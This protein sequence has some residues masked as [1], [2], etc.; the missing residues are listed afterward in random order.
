M[1]AGA[2]KVTITPPVGTNMAGFGARAHGS[3]ASQ[4]VHD[5]LYAKALVFEAGGEWFVLI[6]CDLVGVDALTVHRIR[7]GIKEALGIPGDRIWV[8]ATHCHSGPGLREGVH[9]DRVFYGG[10]NEAWKETFIEKTA[11]VVR[12]AVEGL[13]PAQFAVGRG[14]IEGVASSRRVKLSDGTVF[15]PSGKQPEGTTRIG[16]GPVD[17][18]LM[19]LHMKDLQGHSIAVLMNYACHPWIYA[20]P[21]L[22]A[23][24]FGYA[25]EWVEQHI[26]TEESESATAIFSAGAGGDI[27]TIQH[28]RKRQEGLEAQQGWFEEELERLGGIL[29]QGA[30][31]VLE[32]IETYFRP[33]EIRVTGGAVH[34]PF[35]K[36]YVRLPDETLSRQEVGWKRSMEAALSQQE[37][38][39]ATEEEV[40]TEV[41]VA[42]IGE[43]LL[44]GLPSEVLVEIG[45][46]IKRRSSS[47]DTFVLTCCNDYFGYVVTEETAREGGYEPR[48]TPVSPV[49]GGILREAAMK[50]ILNPRF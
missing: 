2:A 19:V 30:V 45:L 34:L 14:V 9:S 42:R 32:S 18:E 29:G 38:V 27:T 22:S 44:V 40:V 46:E 4:G 26:R 31:R 13:Q 6:V 41:Q 50:Q 47:K 37:K 23:E 21:L 43:V 17:K 33:S 28:L 15:N 3:L 20:G 25:S 11:E 24:I 7:R 35:L 5:D 48:D 49:A 16:E 36:P 8:A 39:L 10:I 1:Q 12:Q